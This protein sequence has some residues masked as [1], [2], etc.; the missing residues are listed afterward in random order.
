MPTEPKLTVLMLTQP[1]RDKLRVA[2]WAALCAQTGVPPDAVEVLVLAD[3]ACAFDALP[4]GLD[5]L[6]ARALAG[7][8]WASEINVHVQAWPTLTDKLNA[9]FKLAQAPFVTFWDDDDWAEP[10]RVAKT[11]DAIDDVYADVY[12]PATMF[13]HELVAPTRRTLL[14]TSP[15][16]LPCLNGAVISR[17]LVLRRPFLARGA[18]PMQHNVGVWLLD[19]QKDPEIEFAT[20]DV[21]IVA[22]AHGSNLNAPRQYRV[23]PTD[24]VLDGNEYK[25]IGS[26]GAALKVMGEDALMRFEAAVR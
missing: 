12:G 4:T 22:M 6:G 19:L 20:L 17:D 10:Q 24:R 2:A 7:P 3:E 15:W 14:Y 21:A 1:S 5:Q 13:R 23:D 9:G 8:T 25:A 18:R 11:L 26:R 16:A